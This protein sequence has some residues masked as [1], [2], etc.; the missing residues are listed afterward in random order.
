MSQL[1]HDIKSSLVTL[2]AGL[3]SI[4]LFLPKLIET[5]KIAESNGLT[6]PP[7]KDNQLDLL[8]KVS[9]QL[10]NEINNLKAFLPDLPIR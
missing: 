3:E 4:T 9:R 8:L 6:L 10:K 7:V 2:E 1:S 5:Y